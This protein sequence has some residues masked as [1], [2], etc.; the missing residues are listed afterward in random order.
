[1][2]DTRNAARAV[3][4]ARR[5]VYLSLGIALVPIGIVVAPLPGPFGVPIVA[6]GIV[7]I[8]TAN[9]RAAGWVRLHR[10]RWDWMHEILVKGEG[11][12]GGEF[13]HALRRTNGRR[14]GPPGAPL[15]LHWRVLDM[16]L[17]PVHVARIAVR[18]LARRFG[19]RWLE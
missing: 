11:W 12:I 6:T 8:I 17:L 9:R 14:S 5:L 2:S 10:R 3:S 15:P 1:M 13:G 19:W 16:L 7:L 4:P 18:P